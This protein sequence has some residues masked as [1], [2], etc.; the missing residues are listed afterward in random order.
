M[1]ISS[2]ASRMLEYARNDGRTLSPLGVHPPGP[3]RQRPQKCARPYT[4]SN[5]ARCTPNV[6]TTRITSQL[7]RISVNYRAGEGSPPERYLASLLWTFTLG[8]AHSATTSTPPPCGAMPQGLLVIRPAPM[9]L[10]RR[11]CLA[12]GGTPGENRP[13]AAGRG[14]VSRITGGRAAQWRYRPCSSPSRHRKRRR[15]GQ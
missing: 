11:R 7:T 4:A 2:T 5:I 3:V 13:L 10:C 15:S 9:T 8:R 12:R 1:H 14:T 6:H